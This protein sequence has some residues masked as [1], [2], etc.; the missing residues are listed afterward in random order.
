MIL[1]YIINMHYHVDSNTIYIILLI[2]LF[3]ITVLVL[4]KNNLCVHSL[5]YLYDSR[6]YML[7][8][9]FIVFIILFFVMLIYTI[10]SNNKKFNNIDDKIYDD[11]L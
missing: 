3:L 10:N 1:Y 4:E 8:N 11:N 9:Y 6:F 2:F 5:C 7:T